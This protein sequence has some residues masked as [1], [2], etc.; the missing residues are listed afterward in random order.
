[1]SIWACIYCG[2]T[3]ADM[4]WESP[5]RVY[6]TNLPACKRREKVRTCPVCKGT[7]FEE[8]DG[9]VVCTRCLIGSRD[10]TA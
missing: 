1:M 2:S 3:L 7:Q 4:R 5:E 8:R 9:M 10:G 6:C